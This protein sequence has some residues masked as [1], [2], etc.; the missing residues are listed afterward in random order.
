[1]G[2]GVLTKGPIA[3]ALPL[4]VAV[5]YAWWRRASRAIWE[6]AGPLLCL[7]IVLPWVLAVSR[8]VPDFVRY[9]LVTETWL[10]L[11]ADQLQRTGPVWYFPPILLAGAL[12]WSV[13]LLA[14]WRSVR[15]L[16]HRAAFLLLWIA[17]P[18]LFFTLSQSKRP[19]YMLPL[20][21]AM[22]LLVARLWV[23]RRSVP[24]AAGIALTLGALGALLAAG[25]PLIPRL[26]PTTPDIRAAIPGTALTLGIA[27]AAAAVATWAARTRPAVALVGLALPV[28]TIPFAGGRLMQAIGAE[29]SAAGIAQAIAP[30]LETQSQVLAVRAFPLSLPFY[31]RRTVLLASDDAHELTSNYLTRHDT[32][33]T[34][35]GS[36]LRPADWWREALAGCRARVFVVPAADQETRR[37]LEARVPLLI[38]TSRYAAYG[39]CGGTDL[40]LAR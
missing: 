4:L 38:E 8:P 33:R 18:L 7:A 40:A 12:P 25:Y 34:A 17:V 27:S 29:R 35:L 3:L 2:L 13:V 10:R 23:G 28:S 26:L 39:P 30:V 21:P 31:L 14:G 16:D 22:G 6:P 11:T 32:W 5:P 9:A 36:S 37:V 24:G 20:I 15:P 19:Q 1:M